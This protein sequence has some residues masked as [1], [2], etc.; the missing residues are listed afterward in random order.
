MNHWLVAGES[1]GFLFYKNKSQSFIKGLSLL[2][3]RLHCGQR[4]KVRGWDPVLDLALL[5]KKSL[6]L[7][8]LSFSAV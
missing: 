1:T 2:S 7:F 5:V 4:E 6:N 3:L 8:Y